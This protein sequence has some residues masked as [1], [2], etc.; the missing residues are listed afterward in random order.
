MA[1]AICPTR[2]EAGPGRTVRSEPPPRV[3]SRLRCSINECSR[4]NETA[5]IPRG[6][7]CPI[8]R[9]LS[10]EISL[11]RRPNLTSRRPRPVCGACDGAQNAPP[12]IAAYG[13]AA[14]H[15]DASRVRSSPRSAA[16][17]FG[18]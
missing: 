1:G 12:V 15:A 3:A 13:R 8:C 11:A 14:E 16:A 5:A 7:S 9:M 10:A 17:M 18:R 2:A 4:L 6:C